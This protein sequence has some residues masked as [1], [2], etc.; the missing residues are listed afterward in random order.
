MQ[1]EAKA[2]TVQRE[3]RKLRNGVGPEEEASDG[4]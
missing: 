3:P 4:H 2:L 1:K